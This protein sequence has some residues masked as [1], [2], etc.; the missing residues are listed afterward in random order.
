MTQNDHAL[1]DAAKQAAQR[2]VQ[3]KLL[4]APGYIVD[5]ILDTARTI[6]ARPDRHQTG[7]DSH[8]DAAA[9][10]IGATFSRRA[11]SN[12]IVVREAP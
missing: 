1:Q 5:A 10:A 12:V 3:Y 7:S 11:S 2:G 4:V 8:G 6:R 9:K